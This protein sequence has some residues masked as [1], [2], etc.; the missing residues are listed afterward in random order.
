MSTTASQDHDTRRRGLLFVIVSL[1]AG[2]FMSWAAAAAI[3]SSNAPSDSAAVEQGQ[4]T[5]IAPGE[6][7]G[8]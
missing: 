8:Y 6:K 2:A 1:L 4:Q 3:V 5:L 7:I